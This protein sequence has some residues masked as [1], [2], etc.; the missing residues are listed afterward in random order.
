MNSPTFSIIVPVYNVEDYL[1]ECIDSVLAQTFTDFECMLIDD[2]STDESP[3]ICD[4]YSLKDNRIKVI[5]K[6]NGGLSDARNT[7]ILNSTGEYIILLDSDD[8]LSNNNALQ[9]LANLT[10]KTNAQV[11]FNSMYTTFINNENVFSS[12][13][14]FSGNDDYYSPAAFYNL[15]ITCK[16]KLAGWLFI[17]QRDFLIRNNLF[18]KLGTSHEDEL[19]MPFVICNANTIAINHNPFYSYRKNRENSIVFEFNPGRLIDMQTIISDI[20]SKRT[21]IS[22]DLQFILDERC[23]I[24]WN[25]IFDNVFSLDTKYACGKKIII[26]NIGKQKKVLLRN[27]KIKNYILFF[28]ISFLG[29]KNTYYLRE[30]SRMILRC[31]LLNFFLNTSLG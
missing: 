30:K 24:L 11:I 2:G 21:L 4:T 27:R 16:A 22:K 10:N 3:S 5:H 6:E 23:I 19:W 15:I 28:F 13:E 9:N 14:Q 7:G 8:I 26:K 29:T 31:S 20:Q 17:V 1:S 18:F 25:Y 12:C